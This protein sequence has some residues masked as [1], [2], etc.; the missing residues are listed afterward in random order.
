MREI[1]TPPEGPPQGPRPSPEI[2][3]AMGEPNIFAMARDF[4]AELGKSPIR[5]KF[6]EDLEEASKKL[7]MFLVPSFGGPPL[8]QAAYGPPRMRARHL[9]FVIGPRDREIWL[10]CFMKVLEGAPE[11][12]AFPAEHLG[13]FKKFLE[14]F[15]AWMVNSQASS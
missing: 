12:Y 4:Y 9:P 6:P 2:Y 7:A 13:D 1:H 14:G 15:S 5:S 11:R 3:A 8:Y 10:A